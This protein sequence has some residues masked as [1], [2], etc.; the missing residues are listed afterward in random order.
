M[1]SPTN[2]VTTD[3]GRYYTHPEIPGRTFPSITTIISQGV[4]KPVI[5]KWAVKKTADIA[6]ERFDDLALLIHR[7]REEK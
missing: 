7:S 1:T 3:E 2:A 6:L 5:S 4:P